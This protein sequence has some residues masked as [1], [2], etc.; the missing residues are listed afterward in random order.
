MNTE[1]K[2]RRENVYTPVKENVLFLMERLIRS[3]HPLVDL[4]TVDYRAV[5]FMFSI[6]YF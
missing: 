1:V 4:Q 3:L 5:D 2:S 6:Y